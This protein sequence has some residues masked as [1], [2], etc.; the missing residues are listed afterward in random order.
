MLVLGFLFFCA[1]DQHS[2]VVLD[3]RLQG[4]NHTDSYVRTPHAEWMLD[5][6]GHNRT[7]V[8]RPHLR[9][10]VFADL[11]LR[12]TFRHKDQLHRKSQ[13]GSPSQEYEAVVSQLSLHLV[14]TATRHT[15]ATS[16]THLRN[17]HA[18]FCLEAKLYICLHGIADFSSRESLRSTLAT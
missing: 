5:L 12:R 18:E 13:V 3:Q 9:A 6:A 11:E 10:R 2:V 1:T 7:A 14:D 8:L 15:C 17:T 16:D 4:R